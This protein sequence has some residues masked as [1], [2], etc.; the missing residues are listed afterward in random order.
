MAIVV[1]SE[2]QEAT[3]EI[4]DAVNAKLGVQDDPPE[5]LIVHTAGDDAGTMR[6]IDVWESRES[7][8]RFR[9]ERLMPAVMEAAK[10]MGFDP[11]GPPPGS[12]YEAHDLAVLKTVA[13]V[14]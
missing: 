10:E 9:D 2:P 6:I 8:E 12:V 11:G 13:P 14:G 4:Y 5:G 7:Y 1:I 3:L